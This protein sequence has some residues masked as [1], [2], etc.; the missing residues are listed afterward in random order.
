MIRGR[1]AQTADDELEL[2]L[3]VSVEDSNGEF[4]QYAVIVDTGLTGA[5]VLPE[6]VIKELGLVSEGY[7]EVILASG[8]A[9]EFES[10]AARV[11]WHEEVR[12]VDVFQSIDQSCWVCNCSRAA[13]S[14]W[15]PGMAAT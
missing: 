10:Y 12:R 3:A 8:E 14:R 13:G 11:R 7:M 2:W 1:V 9:R 6:A 4:Q 5:L 15:M